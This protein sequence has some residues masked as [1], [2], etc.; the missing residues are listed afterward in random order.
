MMIMTTMTIPQQQRMLFK[1]LTIILIAIILPSLQNNK[2]VF[3]VFTNAN[4]DSQSSSLFQCRIY[5]AQSSIPNAGFGI[6]T[7]QTI[8]PNQYIYTSS[9]TTSTSF[10]KT[11]ITTTN[12][13]NN[14]YK[15]IMEDT[16]SIPVTDFYE[17]NG[18]DE[19]DWN[20]VDYIWEPMGR[21]IAF[22]SDE[23]CEISLTFGS[24]CNFHT[25]L[26]NLLV[27]LLSWRIM[28][29]KM[30]VQSSSFFF[31]KHYIDGTIRIWWF[32]FR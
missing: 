18:N 30:F 10:N 15:H 5:L 24:L 19:K 4:E 27:S 21:S 8:P 6:Y 13:N 32:D 20:Q 9:T 29:N 2:N 16:P 3:V 23:V 1:I 7:T 31:C 25:V 12:N 14:N 11:T 28:K 17:P 26:T 22:E